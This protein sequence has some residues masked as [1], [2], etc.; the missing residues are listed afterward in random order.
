[1]S[2]EFQLLGE[3]RV[4]RDGT[5]I[6]LNAPKQRILLATLLSRDSAPVPTDRLIEVLW[7]DS[8]PGEPR[9]ALHWHVLKLR[10]TLGAD[11]LIHD[12]GGF[13]IPVD[14]DQVDTRRFES[15]MEKA[16][17]CRDTD[18]HR[19]RD[20]LASALRLWHGPAYGEL[21]DLDHLRDEASRLDELRSVATEQHL[22]LRLSAGEHRRIVPELI[23]LTNEQPYRD[24]LRQLLMLA[25]YRSGRRADALQVYRDGRRRMIEELGLEPSAA[26]RELQRRIL[27]ADPTL[28]PPPNRPPV[29]P[30]T[31]SPLPAV[32]ALFTGRD[33][34][35]DTIIAQLDALTA[36]LPADATPVLNLHGMPGVGKTTAAVRL[37]HRLASRYPDGQLFIDLHGHAVTSDI[38]SPT[39]ALGRLLIA[40]GTPTSRVPHHPDDRAVAL[41]GRLSGRRTLLLLDDAADESQVVPLLPTGRGNLVLITSR[42]ALLGLD[43]AVPITVD[44]L[45]TA[46]AME[47]FHRAAGLPRSAPGQDTMV[48]TIVRRCGCLPL[49]LRIAAARLS[50]GEWTV[51][52]LVN[53]FDTVAAHHLDA[54]HR[55]VRLAFD[56]SYRN[57]RPET[58]RM[59]R[60]L[61]PLAGRPF[62]LSAAASLAAVPPT[63][64]KVLLDELVTEHLVEPDQGRYRF[65]DLLAGYAVEALD[66]DEPAVSRQAARTRLLDHYLHSGHAAALAFHPHRQPLDL[67]GPAAGT[68]I[69]TP[70]GLEAGLSWLVTNYDNLIAA[71]AV[72][73]SDNRHRHVWQLAWTLTTLF[74][75]HGHWQD[76]KRVSADA[77][78]AAEAHGQVMAQAQAHSDLARAHSLT[79]NM[80]SA[81]Q[82]YREALRLFASAG[83]HQRRCH[84]LLNLAKSYEDT[85]QWYDAENCAREAL[86]GYRELGFCAGVANA[87]NMIGWFLAMRGELADG[88]RHCR[89][90]LDHFDS[91]THPSVAAAVWDSIG[92]IHL[93]LGEPA[94]AVPWLRRAR[95]TA[96]DIGSP[97]IEAEILL[98]LGDANQALGDPAAAREVWQQAHDLRV[99]FDIDG[100]EEPLNRMA[101]QPRTR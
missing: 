11:L 43:D 17:A 69:D 75:R 65:H 76:W 18:P 84:T 56:L 64:T 82:H 41:R 36:D 58:R 29:R 5:P 31:G 87:H 70:E 46:S 99:R 33:E 93:R 45:S 72:A 98:R 73:V 6:P 14:P 38:V 63:D 92:T 95:S 66:H 77:L 74:E 81:R 97:I 7:P 80:D 3:I 39:A 83:D 1:M 48:P 59:F 52:E 79:D 78:R 42:R 2:L 50:S 71:I 68:V 22:E 53:R 13:V 100:A 30:A 55:S 89:A 28:E 86:T 10:R 20:L 90:A 27:M 15:L 91:D 40:L 62:T 54:G 26:L 9:K 60:M 61:A 16:S 47:L 4:L 25:L 96:A 85:E 23:T 32:T 94:E 44:V 57:L 49:A 51:T 24:G 12:R 35:L 67:R 88:L 37:A 21:A 34:Q 19:S 101:S 8:P